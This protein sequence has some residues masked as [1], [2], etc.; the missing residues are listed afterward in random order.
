MTAYLART[1]LF[2]IIEVILPPSVTVRDHGQLQAALVR[3]QTTAF[4]EDAYPDHWQK[5]AALMQSLLVGHPLSDGNKRLAWTSAKAFL[6]LN[7]EKVGAPDTD[8][9][10]ELVVAV[11]IGELVDVPEIAG[12]LRSLLQ[13]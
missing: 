10:Y 1:D 7:G 8:T 13:Y 12:R 11:T 3:P 9:A 4:G 6:D 5:A 2:A